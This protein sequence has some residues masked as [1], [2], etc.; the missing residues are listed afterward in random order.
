MYM[1]MCV[2]KIR[3]GLVAKMTEFVRQVS[4]GLSPQGIVYKNAAKQEKSEEASK[5]GE[6]S[7][8]VTIQQK[9][10]FWDQLLF[11]VGSAIL[12]LTLLDISVEF[13]R[14]SGGVVCF[15]P[16]QDGN[17]TRDQT[18]FV[19][20][21]CSQSLPLSEFY[22]IFIIVQGLLLLAPHYMWEALFRGYLDF[23]FSLVRDL[24]HLRNPKSGEYAERNVNIV[25]KLE[26]EFSSS[27]RGIF[28]YYVVKNFIQLAIALGSA[29]LSLLLFQDFTTSFQ[30]PRQGAPDDWPMTFNVTCVFTSLRILSVI[31]YADYALIIIVFIVT[32]YGLVWC[33]RRHTT[34]LGYQEIALFAF[35]S[36]LPFEHF[37]FPSP[38]R[39]QPY[40]ERIKVIFSP[41]IRNDLD[42]LL[43]RLFRA[44]AG[45]GQVFKD[46]QI[47][48]EMKH[49]LDQDHELLH[50]F[51]SAQQD[52]Y[53]RE[54]RR[55]AAPP[56]SKP[57]FHGT[58]M[59]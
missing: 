18:A 54:Q 47:H 8:E 5:E 34:E 59:L 23:F 38:L 16:F 40:K 24:D 28:R 41:R 11:Y 32:F 31:R 58:I 51:V 20:S 2:T 10:F 19:N 21:Y 46:I 39:S 29:A 14:G 43:M 44:D 9:D 48:K 15:T 36:G 35:T 33:I 49:H 13:L 53:Y 30:C 7:K 55:K 22:P 17:F 12:A 42:F 4:T 6:S 3:A 26:A 37:V 56:D 25:K 27:Q 1:R 57:D 45:I 52:S 50:L